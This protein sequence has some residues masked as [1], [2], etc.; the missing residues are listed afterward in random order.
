MYWMSV[1]LNTI[2]LCHYNVCEQRQILLIFSNNLS[3]NQ[4]S[5]HGTMQSVTYYLVPWYSWQSIADKHTQI[6]ST[7]EVARLHT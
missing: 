7:K 6:H 1:S 2:T 3:E 5:L 4:R